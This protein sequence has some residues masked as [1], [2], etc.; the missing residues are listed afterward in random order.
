MQYELVTCKSHRKQSILVNKKIAI[1][2]KVYSKSFF[3][4][5]QPITT[6]SLHIKLYVLRSSSILVPLLYTLYRYTQHTLHINLKADI[7]R[8]AREKLMKK[9]R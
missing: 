4:L 2:K 8:D 5:V 6:S 9:I 1:A 3:T 7:G